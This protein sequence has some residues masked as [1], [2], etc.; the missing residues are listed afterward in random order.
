[1]F[2]PLESAW[3]SPSDLNLLQEIFERVCMWCQ[4]ERPSERADRLATYL[5]HEFRAG[6]RD[7]AA[8]FEAAMWRESAR[9]DEQPTHEHGI[10]LGDTTIN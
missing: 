3:I 7:E 5:M 2:D 9:G 8:L 6:L 4:I 1:M 10:G